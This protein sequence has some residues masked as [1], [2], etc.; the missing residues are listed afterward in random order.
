MRVM[1]LRMVEQITNSPHRLAIAFL[2]VL[3]NRPRL[4][5]IE[6]GHRGPSG[7]LP[8]R[9]PKWSKDT[10]SRMSLVKTIREFVA[11]HYES[12]SVKIRISIT[13]EIFS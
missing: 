5:S 12:L 10:N 11:L 3:N 9:I 6:L 8:E 1:R 4:P 7:P 2:Q 13:G